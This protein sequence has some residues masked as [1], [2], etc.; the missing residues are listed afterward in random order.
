MSLPAVKNESRS[1]ASYEERE[2]EK[3]ESRARLR[4]AEL[5]QRSFDVSLPRRVNRDHLHDY[6]RHFQ[7]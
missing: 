3:V 6:W 7:L 5:S 1:D 4:I 2:E